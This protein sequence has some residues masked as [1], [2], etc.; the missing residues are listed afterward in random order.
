MPDPGGLARATGAAL[1]GRKAS[2]RDQDG[3]SSTKAARVWGDHQEAACAPQVKGYKEPPGMKSHLGTCTQA[4]QLQAERGHDPVN[5][6][7]DREPLLTF[8]NAS[9][10]QEKSVRR[11]DRI[12]LQDIAGKRPDASLT[13]TGSAPHKE[14][15]GQPAMRS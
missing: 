5:T 9:R 15:K 10:N 4:T 8:P 2:R 6:G 13:L 11:A 14:L 3:E 12:S 7:A 1:T